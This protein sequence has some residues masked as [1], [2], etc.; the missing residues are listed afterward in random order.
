MLCIMAKEIDID[1]YRERFVAEYL[2]DYNAT[3]AIKR[4]GYRGTNAKLAGYK[5][6]HDPDTESMVE[7]EQAKLLAKVKL[8]PER[9]LLELARICYFDV[10]RMFDAKG[11][12]IP[13]H[14]LDED[15]AAA[16]N[17]FE[18]ME[19]TDKDGIVF[20]MIKKYKISSKNTALANALKTLG[21]LR[22]TVKIEAPPEMDQMEAAR[23]IAFLLTQAA[24]EMKLSKESE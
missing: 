10:R 18:V 17:G 7:A 5:M 22:E 3:A 19:A 24:H 1:R 21:M 14:L 15:T 6:I 8:T 13:V 2:V 20:G 12:P 11:A 16:I 4:A 9:T 23:R